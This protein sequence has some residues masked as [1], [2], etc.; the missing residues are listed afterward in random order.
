MTYARARAG[1]SL[2]RR[3]LVAERRRVPPAASETDRIER[4]VGGVGEGLGLDATN[5]SLWVHGPI[6]R[7]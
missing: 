3:P 7:Y 1:Q 2:D 4:R 6:A 5:R